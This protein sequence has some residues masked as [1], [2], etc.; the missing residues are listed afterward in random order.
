[1]PQARVDQPHGWIEQLARLECRLERL[2][3][4]PCGA[5]I[6]L[7]PQ[8]PQLEVAHADRGRQAGRIPEGPGGVAAAFKAGA[9]AGGE[10]GGLVEEEEFGIEIPDDAAENIQSFGDAV[11]FIEDAS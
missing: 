8:Q 5:R 6:G 3:Q 7:G 2:G 4:C 11:K 10:G 9:V 1:M